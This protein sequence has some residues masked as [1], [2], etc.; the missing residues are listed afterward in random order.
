MLEVGDA[1]SAAAA[2]ARNGK[3][4]LTGGTSQDAMNMNRS[5]APRQRKPGRPGVAP[6]PTQHTMRAIG[7]TLGRLGGNMRAANTSCGECAGLG[8]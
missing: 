5:T 7:M 6:T 3:R 1:A 4:F 8:W 2:N